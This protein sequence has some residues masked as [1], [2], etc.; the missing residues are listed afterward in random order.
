MNADALLSAATALQSSLA[1]RR[2]MKLAFIIASTAALQPP[3]VVV[4]GGGVGDTEEP[5]GSAP[6]RESC[7]HMV[8]ASYPDANGARYSSESSGGDSCFAE[9]GMTGT[10][11]DSSWQTCFMTAGGDASPGSYVVSDGEDFGVPADHGESS[12]NCVWTMGCAGA[13]GAALGRAAP[14][15]ERGGGAG[16]RAQ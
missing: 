6:D 5:V 9:F 10:N 11:S 14:R 1:R 4:V 7:T 13:G 16:G 3:H 8:R 15:R 2:A 12:V